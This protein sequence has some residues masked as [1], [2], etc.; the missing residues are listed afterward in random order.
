MARIFRSFTRSL[1]FSGLALAA[2]AAGGIGSAFASGTAV[3]S[4]AP[5][6]SSSPSSTHAP[7]AAAPIRTARVVGYGQGPDFTPIYDVSETVMVTSRPVAR[8]LINGE[9]VDIQ[10]DDE[11][12]VRAPHAIPSS[13][14][15]DVPV[16]SPLDMMIASG[17]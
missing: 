8:V 11:A 16:R 2:I 17:A 15:R 6:L 12:A 14:W 7:T 3:T 5:A 10:Y 13:S 9:N 4:L 1:A